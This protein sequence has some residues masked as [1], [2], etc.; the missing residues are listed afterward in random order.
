MYLW[1]F[2]ERYSNAGII[3]PKFIAYTVSLKTKD[4]MR[5]T[6]DCGSGGWAEHEGCHVEEHLDS[7]TGRTWG[8]MQLSSLGEKVANFM[9]ITSGFVAAA[10]NHLNEV[11]Y[12]MCD[13]GSVIVFKDNIDE[14]Y[15]DLWAD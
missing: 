7:V 12:L 1:K 2:M 13:S 15:M 8:S 6:T 9:S 5:H 3:E 11:G 14:I 10:I 4:G